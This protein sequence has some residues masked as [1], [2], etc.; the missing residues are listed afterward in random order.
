[1][2]ETPFG[3]LQNSKVSEQLHFTGRVLILGESPSIFKTY[4]ASVPYSSRI[5]TVIE[6]FKLPEKERPHLI[7]FILMNLIIHTRL[8][9]L[10]NENGV[11]FIICTL[12]GILSNKLDALPAD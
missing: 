2:V 11:W 1:M 12:I 7:T 4:D 9:L 3:M 5:E 6:W 10:S 8:G